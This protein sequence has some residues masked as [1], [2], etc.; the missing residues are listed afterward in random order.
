M[1][2]ARNF[3][4][5]VQVDRRAFK[6]K[7]AK[8][9]QKGSVVRHVTNFLKFWDPLNISGIGAASDFKFGVRIHRLD[10]NQKMQK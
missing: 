7:K 10:S 1:D 3:K 9:G 6:P 4:F 8:V 5:G 2:R